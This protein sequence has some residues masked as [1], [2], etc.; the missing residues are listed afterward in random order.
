MSALTAMRAETEEVKRE[1]PCQS[2]AS[3]SYTI[4]YSKE[5]GYCIMDI[6]SENENDFL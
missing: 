6:I 3:K 5:G 1:E 2:V 4:A